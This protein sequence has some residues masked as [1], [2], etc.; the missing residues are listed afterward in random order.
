M[1]TS[2][3]PCSPPAFSVMASVEASVLVVAASVVAVAPWAAGCSS[4]AAQEAAS[5]ADTARAAL[6]RAYRL[7]LRRVAPSAER[8]ATRGSM[9]GVWGVFTV[10]SFKDVGP[11]FGA[12]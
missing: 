4:S 8:P 9:N 11:G 6:Q 1:L 2:V 3:A 10:C 5:T 12:P 7:R